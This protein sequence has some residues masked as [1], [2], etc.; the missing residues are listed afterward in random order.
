MCMDDMFEKLPKNAYYAFN[1]LSR[2]EYGHVLKEMKLIIDE[3][4][5][6]IYVKNDGS[7]AEAVIE[8]ILLNN[9]PVP[10]IRTFDDGLRIAYSEQFISAVKKLI[11]LGSFTPEQ[12]SRA[13]I[14]SGFTDE[15]HN[16]LTPKD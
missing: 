6:G 12:A 3:I 10:Q 7:I 9:E 8:W 1:C 5:F 16:P 15:S 13:L 4:T 11:P 14:E 2:M